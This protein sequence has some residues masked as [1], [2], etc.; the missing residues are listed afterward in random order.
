[1]QDSDRK[2][3]ILNLESN[4]KEKGCEKKIEY[5][6]VLTNAFAPLTLRTYENGDEYETWPLYWQHRPIVK[7]LLLMSF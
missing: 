2:W 6:D 7:D 1:M 4:E 3:A 5:Y